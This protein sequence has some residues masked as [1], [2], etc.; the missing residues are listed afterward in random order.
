MHL[1]LLVI[2]I[3]FELIVFFLLL[4]FKFLIRLKN[5]ALHYVYFVQLATLY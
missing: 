5:I 1:H 3:Q 2:S 4:S